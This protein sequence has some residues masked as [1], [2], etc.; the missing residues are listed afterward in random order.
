MRVAEPRRS[1]NL[2]TNPVKGPTLTMPVSDSGTE[3]IDIP[4]D[5]CRPP[6][7]MDG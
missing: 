2:C 7:R 6:W 5:H 4:E 3:A 1:S